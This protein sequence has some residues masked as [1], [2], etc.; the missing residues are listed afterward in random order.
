MDARPGPF[1]SA[2]W[3][4]LLMINFE[5]N[6]EVLKPFVPRGTE[7]ELWNG[8][9]YVS[10]VGF[11]FLNTRV[12]GVPIPFH[13]DFDEIN[14]RFY[15]QRH[16]QDGCRRGVVFIKE[17][18]PR[19]MIS[20]VAHAAYNENYVTRRMRSQLV[21]PKPERSGRVCYEWKHCGRWNRLAGVIAGEPA[22]TGA[23]S[24]ETFITQ[25]YWGYTP[26]RDGGTIEY[27][28]EHSPW[29]VWQTTDVEFDID[30]AGEYGDL[31]VG[32]LKRQPSSVF[33]AEGSGIVVR[34]GLRIG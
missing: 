22:F 16:A 9:T 11:R 23:D 10:V 1:L 33:V 28:V 18:V 32:T 25:H 34:K 19:W 2:E 3:R 13:R 6:P 20:C 8:R 17:I 26:Q 14:L 7:L 27:E 21:P 4:H 12:L 29:R 31:F 5:I 15:V 24:E 30:P